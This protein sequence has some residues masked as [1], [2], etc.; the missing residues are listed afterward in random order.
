MVTVRGES[1]GDSK[2]Q[3]VWKLGVDGP[4]GNFVPAGDFAF[5]LNGRG[6]GRS[7][8]ASRANDGD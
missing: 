2:I 8:H 4:M 7:W 5:Q 1:S 6:L 3:G